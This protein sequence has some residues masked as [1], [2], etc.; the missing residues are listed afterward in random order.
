M[1]FTGERYVSNLNSAQI[2]YE[3]WHR[4]FYATQFV[5]GKD[6]LD[7]ACGE[8][9]GA[10]LIAQS[11]KSVIGVDISKEAIDF[12]KKHY[13]RSNLSFLQG[14]IEKIP[15]DGVKKF[16]VVASFETIE[17]VDAPVQECFLKEV[18]RL[19]KDDGV[20]VIS[21]P[22]KL[23]YSDI[24]K[25]KNEFHLREFYEQ[26]FVEFLR[27]DFKHV[28]LLGQK[29]FTGSDMWL[30][31]AS[32]RAGSFVE[33]QI[34]NDGKRFIA[35]DQKKQ[36]LYLVAICS[37][38]KV[39]TL[40][41]SLLLDTA[42]SLLSE[43]ANEL[44]AIILERDHRIKTLQEEIGKLGAWGETEEK[45]I[46][47]R[48]D[49]I[50][51]LQEEIGNLT[52][53]GQAEEKSI[54]ERDD[55]IKTLQEEIGKVGAWGQA[56]EKSIRERDDRIKKLQE[57]IEKLGA[58]RQSQNKKILECN[59]QIAGLNKVVAERDDQIKTL[60]EEI[61]KL[62]AWGQSQNKKILECEEQIAGLNKVVAERDGKIT[63]LN[64]TITERNL[65]FGRARGE[66]HSIYTSK[67]WKLIMKVAAPVLF[68]KAAYRNVLVIIRGV[69]GKF[70][71]TVLVLNKFF[72]YIQEK[73]VKKLFL[74]IRYRVK[75]N[76]QTIK[77][78]SSLP[79]SLQNILNRLNISSNSEQVLNSLINTFGQERTNRIM[80]NIVDVEKF[81]FK[82][83]N[84][85]IYPL[86]H[87]SRLPIHLSQIRKRNILFITAEFPSPY[88]GGGNRVLNFIKTL[89][90]DNN[91][92]LCTA[93]L[94]QEHEHIFPSLAAYCRG[95]LKIPFDRFGGNQDEIRKW[96]GAKTIDVVHYEWPRS[97]ENY[98]AGLGKIQIFT[99]MEAVSLRLLMDMER[100]TP[101]SVIWLEKFEQLA[102]A[103]WLEFVQ[104]F[105]VDAR[106]A[107]TE[108]DAKFF[109]HLY[110]FQ[111]YSVL[112]HG[113]GFDE[114]TLP[115]IK[116]EPHT[117]VFVGN[118]LHYPNAEA[119]EFFFNEI[120]KNI[121][122]GIPD[123]RIYVVGTNPT[124]ELL[125]RADGKQIIITGAVTDV[126][127]YIQKAS[128]CIAPL[129]SGTGLRGKVIEYAALRRPF[130]AT[131]I[132]STDLI[133]KNGVDYFC[134]DT[135]LEFSNKIITL[136]KDPQLARR[137]AEAAYVAARKNYDNQRLTGFLLSLYEYLENISHV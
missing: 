101:L 107:V 25:F 87:A 53:W 83:N 64:Q 61:G 124:K 134:A 77:A 93:F 70:K 34:T 71:S 66:L 4:Y 54:R 7:I 40:E 57:E 118:Y 56:E 108:K 27:K 96:L 43:R 44:L 103:L 21:T 23:F 42:L 128:V 95:I 38:V 115:D 78:G 20:L 29:V 59:G 18:K 85:H 50:K 136:L 32:K 114:F 126:R 104:A 123:V 2:S 8:G 48:D 127:P 106:I 73:G 120:W 97:L 81:I 17:H 79:I 84:G 12:A 130:V 91:I 69:T 62:G 63:E 3:H 100:L 24:P 47:E 37:N 46:R 51:K 9:Y 122:K 11:A 117:L 94:T 131:S 65:E 116:A 80:A 39:E 13:P 30:L 86:I 1:K 60:Q 75:Q 137:M 92:Y 74:T 22:N 52:A 109:S 35:D 49:R 125:R 68:T 28:S 58:W 98:V 105:K 15:I 45:S 41:H 55:R 110:P 14:S 36:A 31:D 102:Y 132:A 72:H 16:D 99:F 113:L 19:L 89:S 6:V 88:H 67:K 129:I 111:E 76:L 82:Q 26:E 121:R 135:A 5:E 133:F 90:K 119:M 112:N 33:Y 10:N